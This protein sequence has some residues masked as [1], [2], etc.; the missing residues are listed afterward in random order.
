MADWYGLDFRLLLV[1]ADFFSD[2]A[3]SVAFLDSKICDLRSIASLFSV[4]SADHFFTCFFCADLLSLLFILYIFINK[5][6]TK[7]FILSF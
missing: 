2:A 7:V 1:S 6:T 3:I 5:T 4:T